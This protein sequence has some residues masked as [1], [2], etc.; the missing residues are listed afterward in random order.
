MGHRDTEDI[1]EIKK[2][3][4][5]IASR[6]LAAQHLRETVALDVGKVQ[7]PHA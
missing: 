3:A 5:A 4:F 1:E 6:P 2:S 7:L